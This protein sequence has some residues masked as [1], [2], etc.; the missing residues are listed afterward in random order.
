MLVLISFSLSLSFS[1][2]W[3]ES[4]DESDF[5]VDDDDYDDEDED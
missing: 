3:Y 1:D 2:S 4:G 5:G